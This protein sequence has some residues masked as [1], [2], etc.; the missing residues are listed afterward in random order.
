MDFGVDTDH[1]HASLFYTKY[2]LYVSET[3]RWNEILIM[4]LIRKKSYTTQKVP[5]EA[6][7]LFLSLSIQNY[8][9]TNCKYLR[10]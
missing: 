2:S 7:E 8:R 10:R 1:K 4:S 6:T 3:P 5:G 9:I